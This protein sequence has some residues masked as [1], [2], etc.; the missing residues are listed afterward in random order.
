ML[1]GD[2]RDKNVLVM[3]QS[4]S[5]R[6]RAVLIDPGSDRFGST[7]TGPLGRTAP[8]SVETDLRALGRLFRQVLGN[9]T[10][11]FDEVISRLATAKEIDA[12]MVAG[13]LR[14]A[15]ASGFITVPSLSSRPNEDLPQAEKLN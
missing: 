7:T 1:H 15:L 13:R 10:R 12:S 4:L 5:V 3:P 14:I 11:Q 2:V 8:A 9:A 6:R